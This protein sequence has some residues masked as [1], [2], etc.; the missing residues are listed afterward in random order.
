MIA[1]RDVQAGSRWYQSVLG[2]ASGH[3]GADYEQLLDAEG[4]QVLQLHHGEAPE[5]PHLGDPALS[6]GHGA[7]LWFHEPAIDAAWAR[8]QTHQ[9]RVLEPL[10]PNPLAG[11]REFW[12]RDPDGY[13]VVIA[14]NR[15]DLGG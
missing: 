13:V 14:G 7:L 6:A 8:A 11:H 9:A 12:L 3:G 5:R 10:Q 1:V 4:R 2:L 15:G